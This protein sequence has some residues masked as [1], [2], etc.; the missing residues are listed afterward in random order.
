MRPVRAVFFDLDD[1]LFDHRHCARAALVG[2]RDQHACFATVDPAELEGSHARILEEL[3]LEV[4]AGRVALDA[5]RIERFRRL[6]AW[7][8]LDAPPEVAARAAAAYRRGYL[9]A[10][11][12]VRGAAAL[13]AAV[14]RHARIAVVSNNLLAEQRDKL[15]QCALDPYVDALVVSEEAGASKPDAAIFQIALERVAVT[16]DEAVMIGDSWKNDIEG[17]RTAGIGAVWFNREGMRSPDP[18]VPTIHS[19]EPAEDVLRLVLEPG[20]AVTTARASARPR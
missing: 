8:G 1:T 3:H 12:E 4:M 5:A 20:G 15:R 10:R 7:A 16:A 17:A 6:Y 19:L 13:L 18:E 2:V 9:E 14:Q 11:R